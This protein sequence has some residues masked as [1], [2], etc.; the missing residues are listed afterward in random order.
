MIE[1][2]NRNSG[3]PHFRVISGGDYSKH[4]GIIMLSDTPSNWVFNSVGLS[5]LL[6]E[7]DS[8]E[9]AGKINKLNGEQK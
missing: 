9:I 7:S 6:S 1:F 5:G 4:F 3:E 8:L 2:E